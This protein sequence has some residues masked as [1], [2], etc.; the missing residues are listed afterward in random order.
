MAPMTRDERKAGLALKAVLQ[1]G[2]PGW[3][4]KDIVIVLFKLAK[5]KIKNVQE[6]I[7]VL[8]YRGESGLNA[9]LRAAGQ[10]GLR[11]NTLDA[12]RNYIGIDVKDDPP[13]AGPACDSAPCHDAAGPPSGVSVHGP[14][15]PVDEEANIA[16]TDQA[17]G[18][19][20]D[21]CN[22]VTPRIANPLAKGAFSSMVQMLSASRV[23]ATPSKR[24]RSYGVDHFK[25][26]DDDDD[27]E[28]DAD[29]LVAL[30]AALD[31]DNDA[32]G[33][34]A[35][36]GTM[37]LSAEADDFLHWLQK[38]PP[39][40]RFDLASAGLGWEYPLTK[41]EKRELLL[42]QVAAGEEEAAQHAR[43]C[44]RLY[45][46]KEK[47]RRMAAELVHQM[48]RKGADRRMRMQEG[49][50][51]RRRSKSGRS[52]SGR[53]KRRSSASR[54]SFASVSSPPSPAGSG[55]ENGVVAAQRKRRSSGSKRRRSGSPRSFSQ[56][57]SPGNCSSNHI[58]S[59]RERPNS[60]SRKDRSRP[61]ASP[62]VSLQARDSMQDV[63]EDHDWYCES[64]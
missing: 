20:T 41:N 43:E 61:P 50:D 9:R 42:L 27:E 21:E 23:T 54:P 19:N 16:N 18:A 52:Q 51:R 5:V 53:R 7:N 2:N 60:S 15:H 34:A 55:S 59:A 30:E 62:Q 29:E 22:P 28:E 48:K 4:E 25:L 44:V 49:A 33:V 56:P 3:H 17:H 8:Q 45:L 31:D 1:A 32:E 11:K 39:L 12:L 6:L 10:K 58:K 26:D 24:R 46:E 38:R 57:A 47:E 36:A 63:S 35:C 13:P 14:N 37:P 64:D 40:H